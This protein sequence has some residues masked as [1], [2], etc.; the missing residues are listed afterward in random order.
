MHKLLRGNADLLQN[1]SF[2]GAIFKFSLTSNMVSCLE[3][4]VVMVGT[5]A[6]VVFTIHKVRKCSLSS[7]TSLGE[8]GRYSE[9][10]LEPGETG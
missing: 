8:S 2:K 3:G 4:V 6:I 7:A 5:S 10:L 1:S 9:L